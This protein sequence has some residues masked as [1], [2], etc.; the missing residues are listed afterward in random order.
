MRDRALDQF[1]GVAVLGM[2]FVNLQGNDDAAYRQIVHAPWHGL[3]LA[4]LVFPF[5]VVATGMSAALV[6]GL[7]K[8]PAPGG[9]LRR[10]LL[11]FAI[12]MVLGWLLRPT[13]VLAEVRWP[14]VL[15]RIAIAY[16]AAALLCRVAKSVWA[17]A[18]VAGLLLALHG[19]LLLW[20]VAGGDV[21]APGGGLSGVADRLLPGRLHRVTHDPEGLLSTLSAIASALMGAAAWRLC[22][23]K[24]RGVAALAGA[25]MLAAGLGVA[26]TGLPLNKNLWTPSFALVTSGA[27]V[28]LWLALGVD[29]GAGRVKRG[30]G[31]LGQVALTLYVVHMLLV[32]LLLVRVEGT[33]RLWA[34]LDAASVSVVGDPALASLLFSLVGAVLSIGITWALARRGWLLKV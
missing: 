27:G 31:W 8:A 18:I 14:G 20:P 9:V 3:T 2:V 13:F 24:G 25:L 5:F 7:A 29:D 26:L 30:L 1:R 17:P 10:A 15:Q 16:A 6:S 32:V 28:L 4:D 12:G 23:M 34:V 33:K 22:T 21:L 19:V 11:L